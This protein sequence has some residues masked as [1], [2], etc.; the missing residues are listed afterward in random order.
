MKQELKNLG[1]VCLFF[2]ILF[3]LSEL[4]GYLLSPKDNI[5]MF[6]FFKSNEYDILS[7][8]PN[9][10]DTLFVGDSL[11]YSSI[12]PMELWEDFGYTSYVCA[13][14]AQTI[15]HS[16]DY[17]E[18]AIKSQQ[19][20]IIFFEVN[21][22][23]RDAKKQKKETMIRDTAKTLV[24]ITKN[25]ANWK[26]EVLLFLN[27]D[28]IN[29][30]WSSPLKGYRYNLK[31]EKDTTQKKDIY[32]KYTDKEEK[33]LDVNKEY[34][35]KIYKLCQKNNI[36]LILIATPYEKRWN[37]KK[38][39]S[40]SKIAENYNLSFLD[41]NIDNPTNIDWNQDSKD[42]GEHLNYYGALKVTKYYGTY[43][44]E[45]HY[46]QSHK[47]EDKYKNWDEE[48]NVYKKTMKINNVDNDR[49]EEIKKIKY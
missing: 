11:A 3:I 36:N 7:E 5:K 43:L 9:T 23:F 35:D 6:G 25:H 21:G 16:Y 17:I 26:K 13:R 2:T 39:N 48:Y 4:L 34:F 15:K 10:I 8:K 38:H 19:P 44:K 42:G 22:F 49:V 18:I 40:V 45:N 1:K 14:S 41:L 47:D 12:I 33:I 31:K 24:P 20:K 32:M 29:Y 28:P 27:D 46:L 37:Y 30:N